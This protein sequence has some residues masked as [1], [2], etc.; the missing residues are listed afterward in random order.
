MDQNLGNTMV[1]GGNTM[2]FDGNSMVLLM[3]SW[4]ILG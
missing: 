4:H 3:V 2:V 1:L